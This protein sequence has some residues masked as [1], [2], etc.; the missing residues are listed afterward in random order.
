VHDLGGLVFGNAVAIPGSD[1]AAIAVVAA[2][3]AIVHGLFGKELAFTS[4]DAETAQALGMRVQLWNAA[5]FLTIG[6]AIPPAAR[7]L[8]ALPVFAFLT[9]PAVGALALRARFRTSFALAA[10]LGVVAAAGGYVL[11]WL[12]ELPTGATMVVLAAVLAAPGALRGVRG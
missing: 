8:G 9:L 4:F 1:L 3:C 10:A 12:L 11:S 5:L 7:A 6:L 2:V